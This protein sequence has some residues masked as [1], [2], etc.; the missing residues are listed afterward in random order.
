MSPNT[1]ESCISIAFLIS[2]LTTN[3]DNIK[4]YVN[5]KVYSKKVLYIVKQCSGIKGKLVI[6]YSFKNKQINKIIN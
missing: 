5:S 2:A 4:I 1:F 3:F 6:T